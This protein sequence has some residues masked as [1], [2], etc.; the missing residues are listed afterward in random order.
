MIKKQYTGNARRALNI[1]WN[2]AVDYDYDPPFMAFYENGQADHYFNMVIGFVRKY[3]DAAKIEQFFECYD[4]EFG[5]GE[6]A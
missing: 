6:F 1:I 3:F 4:G 2:A 5:A